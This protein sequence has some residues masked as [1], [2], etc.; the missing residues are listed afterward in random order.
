[1]RYLVDVSPENGSMDLCV[2][3]EDGELEVELRG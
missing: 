3:G 2:R 1:M